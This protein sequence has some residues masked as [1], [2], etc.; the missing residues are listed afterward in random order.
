MGNEYITISN[1]TQYPAL[2]LGTLVNIRSS[3]SEVAEVP[4][5]FSMCTLVTSN[6]SQVGYSIMQSKRIESR[7]STSGTRNITYWGEEKLLFRTVFAPLISF[8]VRVCL[9]I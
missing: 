5:W 3:R 6:W 4:W 8:P 1:R 9:Y 7:G 2:L